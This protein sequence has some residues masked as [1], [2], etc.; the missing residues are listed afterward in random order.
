MASTSPRWTAALRFARS[1]L[2]DRLESAC[3][4]LIVLATLITLLPLRSLVLDDAYITYRYARNIT[5]GR[6]FVYNVG[7]RVL[8]TTTPGYTLFLAFLRWLTRI[9][10][11]TL[12]WALAVVFTALAGFTLF[13]LLRP[14]VRP[15]VALAGA[16]LLVS[17][18][19]LSSSVGMETS[20]YVF[21]I[22]LT[23]LLVLVRRDRVWAGL[24][25]GAAILV[26]P[27]AALLLSIPL[28][29]VVDR[30]LS[31]R[32]LISVG[33]IAFAV[34][35][36]WLIFSTLYF[37]SPITHTLIAKQLEPLGLSASSRLF[38]RGFATIPT[39]YLGESVV[40]ALYLPLGVLGLRNVA[41]R[42]ARPVLAVMTW[43]VLYVL[44]LS[45]LGLPNY[46]IWYWAPLQVGLVA[47]A[48]SGIDDF[49]D[50]LKGL[51]WS[52][53]KRV[54]I[55]QG[56]T[57]AI[58]AALVATQIT[59]SYRAL[60]LNPR[61]YTYRSVGEYLR[62]SSPPDSL[63]ATWEIGVIGYYSDRPML[64]LYGLVSPI[65]TDTNYLKAIEARRPSY[66]IGDQ[67]TGY[68]TDRV[69]QGDPRGGDPRWARVTVLKRE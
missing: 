34:V 52:Q 33:V 47:L 27:D 64:D 7:E 4:A 59:S 3:V 68:T 41:R 17:N 19:V 14:W 69:F 29:A 15:A 45:A 1:R 11:P 18:P 55:W 23:V 49:L 2:P 56:S 38:V 42:R 54:L 39:H 10:F 36:P 58:V 37:G 67:F 63:V 50:V 5:L 43:C 16:L 60:N 6:G 57:L 22:A 66:I 48:A 40:Y 13:Q 12:S 65:V 53:L 51:P 32:S 8:G 35:V 44:A 9:D 61:F 20:L 46:Y 28:F 21:F 26:R 62:T 24:V 25:I 31:W 30:H